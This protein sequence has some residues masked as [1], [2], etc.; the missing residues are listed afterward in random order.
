[1]IWPG[2]L[3]TLTSATLQKSP[4][5]RGTVWKVREAS[6]II[7]NETFFWQYFFSD[8]EPTLWRVLP[9][10]DPLVD[11]FHSRDLD[12][13][14]SER[15]MAAVNEFHESSAATFHTMRDHKQ[16][17]HGIILGNFLRYN[18]TFWSGWVDETGRHWLGPS[19]SVVLV[20]VFV[21]GLWGAKP[22]NN[23]L[24]MKEIWSSILESNEQK[25]FQDNK[26][27]DQV[28]LT[29]VLSPLLGRK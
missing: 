17:H 27:N 11:I 7:A 4:G 5:S 9:L 19:M 12:S 10:S 28:I 6:E 29:T 23:R 3:I 21:A 20:Y 18:N 24:L 16:H 26:W 15:E 1:M 25:T 2:T 14:P 13:R 22:M 8:L